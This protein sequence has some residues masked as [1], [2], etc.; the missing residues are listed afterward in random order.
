MVK[1]SQANAGSPSVVPHSQAG[2]CLQRDPQKNHRRQSAE[3]L[4]DLARISKRTINSSGVKSP[5]ILL[6]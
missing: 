1:R 3:H 5:V 2:I 4:Y 6:Q